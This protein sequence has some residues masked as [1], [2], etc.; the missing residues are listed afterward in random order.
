MNEYYSQRIFHI[1]LLLKENVGT[2]DK[3]LG[4]IILYQLCNNITNFNQKAQS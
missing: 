2:L 3:S 1:P 4:I